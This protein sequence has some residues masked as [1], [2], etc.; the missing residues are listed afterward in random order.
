MRR[1]SPFHS[2]SSRF[3]RRVRHKLGSALRRERA[4]VGRHHERTAGAEQPWWW[5]SMDGENDYI[6]F[7]AVSDFITLSGLGEQAVL[8]KSIPTVTGGANG[9]LA[10]APS[11]GWAH[12]F[13]GHLYRHE[14]RAGRDWLRAQLPARRFPP[15]HDAEWLHFNVNY[16]WLETFSV[17]ILQIAACG[18]TLQIILEG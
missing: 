4:V 11:G 10:F 7:L 16:P 17:Q 8:N 12:S 5:D 9:P 15:F 2:R 3:R 13:P 1:T 6:Y 18:A 14:R